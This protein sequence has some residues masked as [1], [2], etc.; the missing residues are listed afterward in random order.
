MRTCRTSLN[1][2]CHEAIAVF[3]R[4][5]C[6]GLLLRGL[7]CKARLTRLMLTFTFQAPS[8]QVVVNCRSENQG[9]YHRTE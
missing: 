1:P 9:Q 7:E 2:A 5:A 4:E 8:L 6:S 3:H